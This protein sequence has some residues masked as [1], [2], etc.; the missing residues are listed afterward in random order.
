M[1]VCFDSLRVVGGRSDESSAGSVPSWDADT[2]PFHVE[3]R[4]KD[5]ATLRAQIFFSDIGAWRVLLLSR[6]EDRGKRSIVV[7]DDVTHLIPFEVQELEDN[8]G[9]CGVCV[10][11]GQ[12]HTLKFSLAPFRLFANEHLF[13]EDFR[14]L[15]LL[16]PLGDTTMHDCLEMAI[17]KTRARLES[18]D[19]YEWAGG[20]SACLLE[21]ETQDRDYF[22]TGERR[23]AL[24][25]KE[26]ININ[27]ATDCFQ[28]LLENTQY[29]AH[30]FVLGVEASGRAFGLFLDETWKTTFDLVCS[31]SEK[32]FVHSEGPTFDLYILGFTVPGGLAASNP[33]H[34]VQAFQALVGPPAE[35]P[36]WSLGYHQCRWSYPNESVFEDVALRFEEER[37]PLDCMWLDI[38][39]MEGYKICTFNEER[40]PDPKS[41]ILRLRRRGIRTVTIVDP[42]VKKEDGYGVYEQGKALNAFV[43]SMRDEVFE[44]EVWPNPAVFPDF[45][46][47]NV[48]KWF[49][50]AV[51]EFYTGQGISGIWCD[52]NEPALFNNPEKSLPDV[53]RHGKKLHAEVHNIYGYM[54]CKSVYEGLQALKPV[55]PSFILTRSGFSGIQK[56]AAVWTG[57]NTSTY[58]HMA[59]SMPTMLN[60]CISGVH[61]VGA[62]VG[63]FA[64]DCSSHLLERWTWLSILYPFMRNHAAKGTR[65]QEPFSYGSRTLSITRAAI[66]FRYLILPYLFTQS[67][68][69][70]RQGLPPL[71][72]LFLEFPECRQCRNIQ[73]Q[74]LFGDALMQAPIVTPHSEHRTIFFPKGAWQDLFTGD[75]HVGPA[76]ESVL[77]PACRTALFQRRNTAIPL[78]NS[79]AQNTS[80]PQ[81]LDSLIWRIFQATNPSSFE[82]LAYHRRPLPTRFSTHV[83]SEE[84]EGH[85]EGPSPEA[86]NAGFPEWRVS[87]DPSLSVDAA[88]DLPPR[89]PSAPMVPG[90]AREEFADLS[91][92][93]KAILLSE[94]ESR[95]RVEYTLVHLCS[96]NT[97]RDVTLELHFDQKVMDVTMVACEFSGEEGRYLAVEASVE[98]VRDGAMACTRILCDEGLHVVPQD[99]GLEREAGS[100][101]VAYKVRVGRMTPGQ[102]GVLVIEFTNLED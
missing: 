2:A 64:Q 32:S 100:M 77:V 92:S 74:W 17:H 6:S 36:L 12:L 79:L 97:S 15:R 96:S 18:S 70:C 94:T 23:G 90:G 76:F 27:W 87:G 13:M 60:M 63:G 35:P 10:L 69:G 3:L 31:S 48:R 56:Y 99:L 91:I 73:D 4:N 39:Y 47:K 66:R 57:D 59:M 88:A 45:T 80:D 75:I 67:A 65:R 28:N 54:M 78:Q 86:V 42:G 22:G 58:E 71:R 33:K 41:L 20:W 24:N 49:G 40:F 30:P 61:M 52:M 14:P 84:G 95:M 89:E 53:C 11:D 81:Y 98:M 44:G 16:H 7:E 72:P 85:T 38:D 43:R 83:G 101:Q 68:L 82:G 1:S 34:I 25:R 21:P 19:G 62:D 8:S 50:E 5:N 93:S 46:R 26:T 55:E 29:Q 37:I 102:R 51:A 9:Y